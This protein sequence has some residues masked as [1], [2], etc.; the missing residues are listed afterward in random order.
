MP[1]FLKTA[2]K[3][4]DPLLGAGLPVLG[5]KLLLQLGDLHGR[6]CFGKSLESYFLLRR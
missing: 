6:V 3:Q 2:L 1:D 5:G 4:E